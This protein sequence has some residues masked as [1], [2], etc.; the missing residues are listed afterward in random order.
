MPVQLK[1]RNIVC[2]SQL[3]HIHPLSELF[4]MKLP[5]LICCLL[6]WLTTL[7]WHK[8]PSPAS[9]RD[10]A[11][12]PLPFA[13]IALLSVRDSSLVK[14]TISKETGIYEFDNVQPGQYRLAAS[15]VGYASVR[16]QTVSVGATAAKL[17]ILTLSP[18]TKT[19]GEVT[20]TAQKP[21]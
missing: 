19:L 3:A 15:A 18:A 2:P 9:I 13:S 5:Y 11:G 4:V 21:F 17:P 12:K 14:G 16:S 7:P 20:V 10:E 6:V 8:Q 1:L